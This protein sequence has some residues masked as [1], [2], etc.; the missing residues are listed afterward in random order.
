MN[1]T[2]LLQLLLAFL[3][4]GIFG[5]GGG[6]SAIPLVKAEVVE[7]YHFM[8]E[9]EFLD[10]L[11]VAYTLPG[12]IATKMAA[13]V[14]WKVAG[15][16][17]AVTAV[18]GLVFPSAAVLVGLSAVIRPHVDHPRV[19]GL[20]AGIRP[21]VLGMLAWIVVDSAPTSVQSWAQA[22]LAV[23]ALGALL[24]GKVHPGWVVAGGALVGALLLGP[25]R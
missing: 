3:R 16:S 18:A 14:G 21:A 5:F 19:V 11:A 2:A 12:P 10:V 25:K 13:Q 1:T 15:L 4:V 17:G 8:E 22:V 23:V 24:S 7:R 20:L 6:P 9:W